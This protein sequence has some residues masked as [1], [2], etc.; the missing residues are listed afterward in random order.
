MFRSVSGSQGKTSQKAA[1]SVKAIVEGKQIEIN[2]LSA[3]NATALAKE[4]SNGPV[5]Q[6]T[7]DLRAVDDE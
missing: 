7:V 3:K 5:R 2:N 4:L 6:I 1:T